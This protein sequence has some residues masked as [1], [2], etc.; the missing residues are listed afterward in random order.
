MGN[1]PLCSVNLHFTSLLLYTCSIH[2]IYVCVIVIVINY[3]KRKQT[4]G[5]FIISGRKIVFLLF[6]DL[7]CQTLLAIYLVVM[8]VLLYK[9]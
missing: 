2:H 3:V 5:R 4:Y 1:Q 7:T 8:Y 6:P 9:S